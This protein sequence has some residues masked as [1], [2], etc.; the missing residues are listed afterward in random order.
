MKAAF[1]VFSTDDRRANQSETVTIDVGV[2]P[3][4]F[5]AGLDVSTSNQPRP[6]AW[7]LSESDV[8]H[9][10][11]WTLIPPPRRRRTEFASATVAMLI[12]MP[13]SRE[14]KRQLTRLG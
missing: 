4:E 9:F 8:I 6:R 3:V 1:D 14:G 2:K 7:R 12:S 5:I 10:R 11:S 13:A